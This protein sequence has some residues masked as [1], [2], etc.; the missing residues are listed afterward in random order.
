MIILWWHW[1]VLGLLL[2]AGEIATP[3]GF[4]LVFFG[5]G[6][7][8]VGLLD[9]AGVGGPV[10]FQILAF[11]VISVASLLLFRAR[12][13]RA[14]QG[15][16]QAPAIDTLVGEV[17]TAGEALAP[18]AIGK[19]ELRGTTWTAHN[20]SETA[21]AHGARCRVIRVEGLMLHIFP[22]GGRS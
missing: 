12:L 5:L 6:A 2:V 19:I 14:M 4:Y 22:E 13:L 7:I 15:N 1:L 16:P 17:G 10:A 11:S 20:A 9:S 21:I 8:V 3:G 18:D